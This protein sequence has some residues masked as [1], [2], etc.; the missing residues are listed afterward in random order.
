M[1]VGPQLEACIFCRSDDISQEHLV[2]DWM[3]RAFANSR[4]PDLRTT[5]FLSQTLV[6]TINEDPMVKAGLTCHDCNGG[7]IKDIDDA[8][9]AVMKPLVR[10]EHAVELDD[11]GQLTVANWLFKSLLLWDAL[12]KD[13]N[14]LPSDM[15]TLREPF[16]RDLRPPPGIVFMV[17]PG[18]PLIGGRF[19]PF[20]VLRLEGNI[21]INV[22][23]RHQSARAAQQREDPRLADRDGRNRRRSWRPEDATGRCGRPGRL[24]LCSAVASARPTGPHCSA[25]RVNSP[26]SRE[27]SSLSALG[28]A[29]SPCGSRQHRGELCRPIGSRHQ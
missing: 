11:A 26:T 3:L 9:A 4:R 2:S 6:T 14:G 17:G 21:Q 18:P 13:A 16:K 1:S 12:D 19:Q 27:E 25:R 20:G 7:W 10:S 5:H 15:V 28:R 22:G 29:A 23:R 8:S 24:R